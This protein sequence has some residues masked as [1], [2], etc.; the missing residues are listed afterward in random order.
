MHILIFLV[1][2][3]IV[4]TKCTIKDN[5]TLKCLVNFSINQSFV[6]YIENLSDYYSILDLDFQNLGYTQSELESRDY[7]TLWNMKLIIRN[8]SRFE[9]FQASPFFP[10][11]FNEIF[12]YDSLI[13]FYFKNQTLSS[14]KIC[15]PNISKYFYKFFTKHT[16]VYFKSGLTF[17]YPLCPFIF[18]YN[19]EIL[20]IENLNSQNSFEFMINIEYRAISLYKLIIQNSILILSKSVLSEL[21]LRGCEQIEIKNSTLYEI[22][23][24]DRINQNLFKTIILDLLNMKQ[25]WSLSDKKWLLNL[26]KNYR[27]NL[28]DCYDITR[29]QSKQNKK[30]D[31]VLASSDYDYPDGDFCLFKDFPHTD[32]V[33]P[34]I[35]APFRLNCSCTLIWLILN[36][37]LRDILNTKQTFSYSNRTMKTQATE[38]CFQ[39]FELRIKLCNFDNLLKK[40]P[41]PR[42]QVQYQSKCKKN[43]KYYK[44]ECVKLFIELILMLLISFIGTP[45]IITT[46]IA[47]IKKYKDDKVHKLMIIELIFE[48]FSILLMFY[49]CF[50]R[51]DHPY[52]GEMYNDVACELDFRFSTFKLNLINAK[53][54]NFLLYTFITSANL[55][56]LLIIFYSILDIF[57][58]SQLKFMQEFGVSMPYAFI[59]ILSFGLVFNIDHFMTCYFDFCESKNDL[60]KSMRLIRFTKECLIL[61]ISVLYLSLNF[62]LIIFLRRNIKKIKLLSNGNK[63]F[64]LKFERFYAKPITKILINCFSIFLLNGLPHFVLAFY[65]Y[66]V[67][68]DFSEY[69]TIDKYS[70]KVNAM[71]KIYLIFSN[72]A[73]VVNLFHKLNV[74][75]HFEKSKHL[76]KSIKTIR[77]KLT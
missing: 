70:N 59:L 69:P 33:F 3:R 11:L 17:P 29:V 8:V 21:N 7:K 71:Y 18:S 9:I 49:P 40:C 73:F 35:E 53:L 22:E 74:N 36:W 31:L 15:R 65:K 42:L 5:T 76:R 16:S 41:E 66:K 52:F 54:I 75:L 56:N 51:M 58:P 19:F 61:I 4:D 62:Y 50:V 14:N 32:L 60:A 37:E 26:N 48:S 46:L 25:F 45:L 23:Y 47:L 34:I 2:F 13:D 43:I 64:Y 24:L 6:D 77:N 57:R 28:L 1:L 72:L 68:S 20:S 67:I 63:R 44:K 38:K 39:D 55:S 30:I 10:Q 12:F 27:I